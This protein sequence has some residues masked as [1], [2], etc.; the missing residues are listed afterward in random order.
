MTNTWF[1]NKNNK[2]RYRY[3][4]PIINK[5]E[6]KEKKDFSVNITKKDLVI[7][8]VGILIGLIIAYL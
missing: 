6:H 1:D 8:G 2:Y 3:P 5:D 4:D 7:L